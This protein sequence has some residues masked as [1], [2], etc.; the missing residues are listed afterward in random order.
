MIGRS[1]TQS[2]AGANGRNAGERPLLVQVGAGAAQP[3]RFATDAPSTR[4]PIERPV[5][6]IRLQELRLG[7]A[8]V[9]RGF[10]AF[11]ETAR[12]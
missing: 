6:K 1:A 8:H 5:G 12:M 11:G 10:Q 9:L 4:A 7:S 2:T 3:R